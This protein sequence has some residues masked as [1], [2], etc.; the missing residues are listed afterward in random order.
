MKSLFLFAVTTAA[1]AAAVLLPARH[2]EQ[3]LAPVQPVL[4]AGGSPPPVCPPVC[5]PPCPPSC[6]RAPSPAPAKRGKSK[7]AKIEHAGR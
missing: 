4:L 6:L 5:P 7:P 2:V 1:F 3:S